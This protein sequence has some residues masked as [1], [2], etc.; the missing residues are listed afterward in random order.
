MRVTSDFNAT[1][2]RLVPGLFNHPL[3]AK[4]DFPVR[5]LATKLPAILLFQTNVP[6]PLSVLTAQQKVEAACAKPR[7]VEI[8]VICA[9][10]NRKKTESRSLIE[11]KRHTYSQ[12][13]PK[14]MAALGGFLG[15]AGGLGFGAIGGGIGGLLLGATIG[16]LVALKTRS[17]ATLYKGMKLGVGWGLAISG[18]TGLIGGGIWIGRGE[19]K[20]AKFY[21]TEE[22][23]RKRINN[24]TKAAE[25]E[26]DNDTAV[27]LDNVMY[28]KIQ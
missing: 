16:G 22:G 13:S 27:K 6:K 17:M 24:E 1:N 14:L 18:A 10:N 26:I 8:T 28:K 23:I 2:K 20:D 25:V 7:D 11:S 5:N 12:H 21:Q 3:T 9:E 19:Y 4:T 15:A